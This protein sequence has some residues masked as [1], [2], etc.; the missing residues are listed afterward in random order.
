MQCLRFQTSVDRGTIN[1][2]SP[3]YIYLLQLVANAI[4]RLGKQNTL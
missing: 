1:S 4:D 3:D 2:K